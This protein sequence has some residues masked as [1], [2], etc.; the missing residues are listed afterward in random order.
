MFAA[1]DVNRDGTI[2][3]DE[4]VRTIRGELNEFRTKLV[5]RAFTK[6]D[7]DG[8]GIIDVQDLV[9]VYSAKKHPAVIDGRKTEEQVLSE[10][11]ETFETH[12]NV[13][14]NN[15]RDYNVTPVEFLE[16]YTNISAS[17]DDDMYFS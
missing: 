1:F 11:L 2:C 9:G 17:I 6:L 4:F 8:S 14:N 13:L 7:R 16:Y 12:H 3:Y 5:E 15:E 10:F